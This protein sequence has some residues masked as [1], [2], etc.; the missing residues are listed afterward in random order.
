MSS[1]DGSGT[2]GNRDSVTANVISAGTISLSIPLYE[3]VTFRWSGSASGDGKVMTGRFSWTVGLRGWSVATAISVVFERLIIK[4]CPFGVKGFITR[5][6]E[7]FVGGTISTGAG[8]VFVPTLKIIARTR[9]RTVTNSYIARTTIARGSAYARTSVRH[10]GDRI[11][12]GIF[13]IIEIVSDIVL[14]RIIFNRD[15]NFRVGS[16]TT[17]IALQI[18]VNAPNGK[19]EY[20]RAKLYSSCR[21]SNRTVLRK[22]FRLMHRLEFSPTTFPAP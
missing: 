8:A 19:V 21:S 1:A 12:T 3:F 18:T 22:H 5:N 20:L 10:I 6:R 14:R 4:Q 15:A 7:R 17:R 9:W 16:T 2:T 11:V 13:I